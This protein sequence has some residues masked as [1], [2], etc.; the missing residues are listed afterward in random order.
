MS[1]LWVQFKSVDNVKSFINDL[2]KID[3]D[4]DLFDDRLIVDAKSVMGIFAL[5]LKKPLCLDVPDKNYEEVKNAV[6]Y[7]LIDNYLKADIQHD[8]PQYCYG[9]GVV[10]SSNILL[11]KK[12]IIVPSQ[13]L[14][15]NLIVVNNSLL[16]Q[17]KKNEKLIDELTSREFEELVCE[18]L[19]KNGLIV[20]LTKQTC[21]GGK[22]IIVCENKLIGNIL[23]YVECKK[24]RKDRPIAVNIV[25]ELY[26]TVM[27]D[28]AT[29]G[30]LVTTSYFTK[31]A[32]AF[33][34]KIRNR[35]SL[36]DYDELF[37][38]ISK[39]DV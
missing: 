26:G 12:E 29:T 28:N 15:S 24:H 8:I 21:D 4:L 37:Q 38:V 27:A 2:A 14:I 9:A 25:R 22:D 13:E 16:A 6:N 3:G 11:P 1:K 10:E 32:K 33:T 23:T 34:E 31:E 39:T 20:K 36:M 30:L 18:I 19:D 7:L 5:N 35:M 17:I